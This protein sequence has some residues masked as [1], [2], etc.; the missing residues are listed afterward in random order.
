MNKNLTLASICLLLIFAFIGL[1][2]SHIGLTITRDIWPAP[3]YLA[4]FAEFPI[5][6]ITIENKFLP[7]I[8]TIDQPYVCAIGNISAVPIYIPS[9][10]RLGLYNVTRY[11]PLDDTVLDDLRIPLSYETREIT[12][13]VVPL[14]NMTIRALYLFPNDDADT[15]VCSEMTDADFAHAIPIPLYGLT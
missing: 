1:S 12:L 9:R 14:A 8:I 5:Q 15:P 13:E 3:P 4:A 6:K 2:M 10:W 11:E 7:R